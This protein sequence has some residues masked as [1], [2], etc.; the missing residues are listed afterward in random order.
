MN[1]CQKLTQNFLKT[2][3][4]N[5]YYYN[6]FIIINRILETKQ[7]YVPD[8][9][10]QQFLTIESK[11][12]GKF[13][14]RK[15]N[16]TNFS[17]VVIRYIP[18]IRKQKKILLRRRP[19]IR[20]FFCLKPYMPNNQTRRQFLRANF[21]GRHTELFESFFVSSRQLGQSLKTRFY[22]SFLFFLRQISI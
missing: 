3:F 2:I 12:S 22:F 14:R 5:F 11:H 16:V 6:Y 9:S 18:N 20:N 19:N 1:S 7:S 4:E 15:T 8:P 10:C 17:S 21:P 13:L